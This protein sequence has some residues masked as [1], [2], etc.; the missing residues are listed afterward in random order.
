MSVSARFM[1][2]WLPGGP[3]AAFSPPVPVDPPVPPP[4]SGGMRFSRRF[5]R[6]F[7]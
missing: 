3:P 6:R 4:D 1:F 7:A 5:S 2:W